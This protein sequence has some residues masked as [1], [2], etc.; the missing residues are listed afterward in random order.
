M[1]SFIRLCWFTALIILLS[2]GFK[3]LIWHLI[4]PVTVTLA[5]LPWLEF[6]INLAA[7]ICSL[8]FIAPIKLFGGKL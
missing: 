5:Q 7:V 8:L 2:L 1:K 6:A 4:I 3:T